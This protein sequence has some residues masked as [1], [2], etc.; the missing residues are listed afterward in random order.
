VTLPVKIVSLV[1]FSLS[2]EVNAAPRILILITVVTVGLW[3][4]LQHRQREEA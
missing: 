1:R 4:W 3:A 2:P